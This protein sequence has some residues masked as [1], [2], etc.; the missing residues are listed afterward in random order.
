MLLLEA[1]LA[2]PQTL[3]YHE[4]LNP[5][6]WD[7]NEH[8][9]PEVR[10]ALLRV[11]DNFI[12]TLKPAIDES[13][14]EDICLTGS[15]A[16]YNY[17]PGSDCDV[18]IMIRYPSDIY[19]DYALA[20]K[21]V[22]NKQYHVSI[23][24]FPVEMYPQPSTDKQVAGSGWYSLSKDTWIQKPV[25]QEKVDVTNPSILHVANKMAEQ[26]DFALRYKIHDLKVLHRLGEKIWGLRN[27]DK[28]GEF[29]INNLAFK[30]LRN[31][32]WTDK[33]INYMQ[34]VQNKHLTVE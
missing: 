6:L 23:H 20:K 24:G 29:S 9:K 13:M 8:L 18:H 25:Y 19:A 7:A 26:I 2:L 32:G 16:N 15:N 5:A 11:A 31:S 14:I 22:W 34:E 4:Q 12:E 30:E 1:D 27:Q 33:Y 10:S 21:T 17:T 28:K 3:E